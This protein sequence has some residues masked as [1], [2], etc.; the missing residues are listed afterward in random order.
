MSS[1]INEKKTSFLRL[2]KLKKVYLFTIFFFQ[3]IILVI[4]YRWDPDGNHDGIM[5][6]P[7]I[8][9]SEGKLPNKD[10]FS[11]YG[12]ISPL[13]QGYWLRIFGEN[14]L[15]L[16]FFSGVVT[17]LISFLLYVLV[18]RKLNDLTAAL[19]SLVWILTGPIGLPWSSLLSTLNLLIV[20]LLVA[21]TTNIQGTV[22]TRHSWLLIFSSSFILVST[23]L[24]RVQ[25]LIAFFL[26]LALILLARKDT[27]VKQ[28]VVP[29][30]LG[31]LA[32]SIV[33]VLFLAI[34]GILPG[35]YAQSVVWAANFYGKP[36]IDRAYILNILWYPV[37]TLFVFMQFKIILRI[38]KI[39]ISKILRIGFAN[40]VFILPLSIALAIDRNQTESYRTLFNTYALAN[41]ASSY[42]LFQLGYIVIG[43]SILAVIYYRKKI[44]CSFSETKNLPDFLILCIALTSASQ[45]FPYYDKFHLWFITPIFIVAIAPL[46]AE[47]RKSVLGLNNAMNIWMISI[48][49][50]LSMQFILDCKISR[51]QFK[52]VSMAGTTSMAHNAREVDLTMIALENSGHRGKIKFICPIGIYASADS[53]YL[54]YNGDFVNWGSFY[55]NSMNEFD[56]VFLCEVPKH[57]KNQ[58]LADGYN[59]IWE[60]S[61]HQRNYDV[62][63]QYW[64]I[65]LEKKK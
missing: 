11:L 7:A 16:R 58:Y 20:I 19:I 43:F 57:Y 31:G 13:L 17:F 56:Q 6:T 59:L 34:S 50:V 28:I 45:L 24:V 63:T 64:N 9:V 52:N 2:D 33:W 5:L 10:F 35:Y 65:L 40:A 44:I 51:Y 23:T 15:Q 12:P 4:K 26:G 32:A 48:I 54:S 21:R 18:R 14:L 30:L 37:I 46:L 61:L 38:L 47:F 49:L 60:L 55:R 53:K 22:W 27:T 8:A 39:E 25:A 62:S 41:A 1:R 36:Y 29:W 42:L 3:I